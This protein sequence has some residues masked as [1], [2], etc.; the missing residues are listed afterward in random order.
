MIE[1]GGV[2]FAKQVVVGAAALLPVTQ[3]EVPLLDLTAVLKADLAS[4][5][6]LR[7][8]IRLRWGAFLIVTCLPVRGPN[9]A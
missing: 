1:H 6:W 7:P 4:N 9:L 8:P 2:N 3:V 5:S